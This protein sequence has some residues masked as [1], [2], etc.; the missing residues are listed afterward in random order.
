MVRQELGGF[1][2]AQ[3]AVRAQDAFL[4]MGRIGPHLEHGLVE[5]G[6]EDDVVSLAQ[7]GPDGLR[8]V[9]DVGRQAE[10]L[11]VAFDEV[12]CVAVRI[13]GHVERR[14]AEVADGECLFGRM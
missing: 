14:D 13:V 11:S 5:V 7:V 9:P 1:A 10:F 8:E 6:F 4:Q 12:A 2:V 3:V